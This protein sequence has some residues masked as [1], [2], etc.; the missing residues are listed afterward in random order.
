MKSPYANQIVKVSAPLYMARELA[1]LAELPAV[2]PV[3]FSTS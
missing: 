1:K 2:L 3:T